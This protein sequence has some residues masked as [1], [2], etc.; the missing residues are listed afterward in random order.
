VIQDRIARALAEREHIKAAFPEEFNDG[1]RCGFTGEYPGE[2][3]KG[4]YPVGFHFWPEDRRNAW[5]A[6]FNEGYQ[7]R[8]K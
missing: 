6:G 2:R 8:T 4:G 7:Y 1:A 3:L 5:F